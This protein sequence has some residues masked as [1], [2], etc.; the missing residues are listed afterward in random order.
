MYE[1]KYHYI[2]HS[3]SQ[4]HWSGLTL[5]NSRSCFAIYRFVVHPHFTLNSKWNDPFRVAPRQTGAEKK[6]RT[7]FVRKLRRT[8][9]THFTTRAYFARTRVEMA[10]RQKWHC[11]LNF[12]YIFYF[13]FDNALGKNCKERKQKK[14]IEFE[15]F[16]LKRNVCFRCRCRHFFFCAPLRMYWNNKQQFFSSCHSARRVRRLLCNLLKDLSVSICCRLRMAFESVLVED[17]EHLERFESRQNK[18]SH[19]DC[20][21]M[22]GIGV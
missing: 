16:Q 17:V 2:Q 8:T 10:Y 1:M 22:S 6:N 14:K 3:H 4:T 9:N 21:S 15:S 18:R 12:F 5:L 11:L 20:Q 19:L 13:L 7:K